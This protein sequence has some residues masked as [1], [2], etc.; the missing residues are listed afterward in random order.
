MKDIVVSKDFVGRYKSSAR[1]KSLE[2]LFLDG[3]TSRDRY[4]ASKGWVVVE[5]ESQ[6]PPAVSS[7]T[8]FSQED[9]PR[10]TEPAAPAV[11]DEAQKKFGSAK[12]ISSDQFFGDSADS[13][14]V[15]HIS[16]DSLVNEYIYE[17]VCV[18]VRVHVCF[19]A[20]VRLCVS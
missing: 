10:R 9:R 14:V 8:S 16:V 19:C 2:S 20:C 15:T 11:T 13:T 1:E 17:S 7:F 5:P 12:A 18:Y 6:Q 4:A 3:N